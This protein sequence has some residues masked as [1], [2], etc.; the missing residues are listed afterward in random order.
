MPTRSEGRTGA[1]FRTIDSAASTGSG[2]GMNG[3]IP[4]RSGRSL[5]PRPDDQDTRNAGEVGL[6]GDDLE[7]VL[8]GVQGAQGGLLA[9]TD[10]GDEVAAGLQE[11]TGL[12]RQTAMA[13]QPVRTGGKGGARLE[14]PHLGRRPR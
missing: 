1:A 10:L 3:S 6:D 13:N 4:R 2:S 9:E 5:R 7:T 11:H 12:P 8:S 14:I